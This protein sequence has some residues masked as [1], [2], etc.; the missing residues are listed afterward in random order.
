[1]T[2]EEIQFLLT[3]Y[4]EDSDAARMLRE[5]LALRP[6]KAGQ[7]FEHARYIQGSPKAGTAH[8]DVCTV[9]RVAQGTVYYRTETGM[10]M[11]Q[12]E[13]R[14]AASVKRWL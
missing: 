2:E 12:D 10:K 13:S 5:R 11:K 3:L 1:M 9:T 4:P 6:V 7:R 14:F 8:P